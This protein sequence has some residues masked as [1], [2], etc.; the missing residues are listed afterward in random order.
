MKTILLLRH[1]KASH[2]GSAEKDIDR[3]LTKVG[4]TDACQVGSFLKQVESIPAY[5]QCSPAERARQTIRHIVEVA[6]IDKQ[7]V[8]WCDDLYYGGAR[9]YFGVIH[10]APEETDQIMVVGHNPLLEETVSLLCNGEGAYLARM[11]QGGLVCIE[12]PAI[13]W[14]QIKP[15]TARF[16]WMV[17][18]DLLRK[19]NY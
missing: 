12:H 16:R 18:P 15:G 10:S 1:A 14:N 8:N 2:A 5:I 3:I 6:D 4:R 7:L 13:E 17:T 9:D 19:F 11:P